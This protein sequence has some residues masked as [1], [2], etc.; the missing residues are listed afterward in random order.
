MSRAEHT[1]EQLA[2]A[3]LIDA[4]PDLLEVCDRAE[5][6]LG[7]ISTI[8]HERPGAM[9]AWVRAQVVSDALLPSLRAAIARA[10]GGQP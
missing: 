2:N 8:V 9:D 3:R 1:P 7:A 6:I 10:R 5:T 4:A